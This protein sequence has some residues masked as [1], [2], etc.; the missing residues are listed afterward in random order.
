[1]EAWH[2]VAQRGA[3]FGQKRKYLGMRTAMKTIH[4]ILVY[5]LLSISNQAWQKGDKKPGNH[6]KAMLGLLSLIVVV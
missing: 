2:K 3:C 4:I 6:A 5:P 1:M